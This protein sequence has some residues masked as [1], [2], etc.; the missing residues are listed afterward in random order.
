MESILQY[1]DLDFLTIAV[2]VL[3]TMLLCAII[4]NRWDKAS[5]RKRRWF[6]GSCIVWIIAVV[7]GAFSIKVISVH[8]ECSYQD[9]IL[10][11]GKLCSQ[12]LTRL[13]HFQIA[14]DTPNGNPHLERLI[15]IVGEWQKNF[16]AMVRLY[17]ARK[18]DDGKYIFI[19]SPDNDSNR[20]HIWGESD[21]FESRYPVGEECELADDARK[22]LDETYK[23]KD[24]GNY[25]PTSNKWGAFIT[26]SLPVYDDTGKVEAVLVGEIWHD[27]WIAIQR[28]FMMVPRVIT[29]FAW[30]LLL[31]FLWFLLCRRE[32]NSAI[33]ERNQE[34]E[35][36]IKSLQQSQQV[37]QETINAK[38]AFVANMSHEIRTPI[39][40]ILGYAEMILTDI[41]D[42]QEK[43]RS[44]QAGKLHESIAT[45][46]NNTEH[47]L[48]IINDIFDFTKIEND[49]IKLQ[50]IVVPV[51]P[52]IKEVVTLFTPRVKEKGVR[53]IYNNL[54]PFPEIVVT[55]RTRLKQVLLNLVGNAA[56]FTLKGEISILISW[57]GNIDD[58]SQHSSSSSTIST[59]TQNDI[60]RKGILQIEI[61]DTGIGMNAETMSRLFQP[62]QQA[63]EVG[64][65][66]MGGTGLGLTIS[67]ELMRRLG[68]DLTAV[69]EQEYGST[70]TLTLP[71]NLA[72]NVEWMNSVT[73]TQSAKSGSDSSAVTPVVTNPLKGKS[74]LIVEDSLDSQ[75]LFKLVVS[76]SGA[77][78]STANNGEDGFIQAMSAWNTGEPF[79]LIIM[80]MQMPVMDGYTAVQYLRREGYKLPIV[81]LT[82]H[83]LPEERD[84]CISAGCDDY[85]TK[86][87]MQV[88]LIKYVLKNLTE[89]TENAET[90]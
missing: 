27:S 81:A 15:R 78:A 31:T 50:Q 32:M 42:G 13:G 22:Q 70:F 38:S 12:I 87:I 2:I 3:M 33:V 84:R 74:I 30:G 6:F 23:G 55:D 21:F 43:F 24:I 62:F 75:R 89:K 8:T 58:D 4:I 82:A 41:S 7:I 17:T 36:N 9:S 61:R 19:V 52:L 10:L 5:I 11:N 48:Q 66:Q 86:P 64:E 25:N 44:D 85:T 54:T 63:D 35:Q 57:M 59:P 80:D 60:I 40:A 28:H 1:L 73:Q 34:L 51:V 65:R 26:I 29:Y 14:N 76:K 56:K 46:R 79:D 68:G 45:I 20:N 18:T 90:S 47:V 72:N 49:Q 69:S 16:G 88:A 77:S 67:R 83:A 71:Q 53:L 39:T 37:T